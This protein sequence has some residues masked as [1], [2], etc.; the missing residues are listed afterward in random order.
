[1]VKQISEVETR[2]KL[3]TNVGKMFHYFTK[4]PFL[5]SFSPYFGETMNKNKQCFVIYE[6]ENT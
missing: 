4:S 3:S 6:P 2:L 1:M 5:Q